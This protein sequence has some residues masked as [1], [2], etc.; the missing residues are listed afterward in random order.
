[1][2]KDFD[3]GYQ[4]YLRYKGILDLLKR[5]ERTIPELTTKTGYSQSTIYK[6]VYKLIK[7]AVL[8]MCEDKE[9]DPKG[10]RPASKFRFRK[11]DNT[12]GSK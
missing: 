3:S 1:M 8:E 4:T 11:K 12:N 6:M 7:N 9:I 5:K 10:T 2:V